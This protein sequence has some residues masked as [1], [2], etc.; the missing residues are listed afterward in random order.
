MYLFCWRAMMIFS[1][2][3]VLPWN[4]AVLFFWNHKHS[5]TNV[6]NLKD[7]CLEFLFKE[8]L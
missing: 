2:F 5:Y 6:Q 3:T 8:E 7:F 1:D 4:A